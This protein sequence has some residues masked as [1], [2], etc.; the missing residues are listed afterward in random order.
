MKVK[1]LVAELLKFDQEA[2]VI[3][4]MRNGTHIEVTD[5]LDYYPN[6]LTVHL[7]SS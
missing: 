1:D 6:E 7:E 3:L 2:T 4:D 5:S